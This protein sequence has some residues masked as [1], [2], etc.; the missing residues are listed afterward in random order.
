MK[1]TPKKV[2]EYAQQY[3]SYKYPMR[4]YTL[5]HLIIFN[6]KIISEKDKLIIRKIIKN[7]YKEYLLRAMLESNKELFEQYQEKI[8]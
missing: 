5:L 2:W 8:K 3:T 4:P 6:L 7:K 1:L